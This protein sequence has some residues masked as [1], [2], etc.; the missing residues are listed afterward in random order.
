MGTT[1]QTLNK[2][3]EKATSFLPLDF[4]ESVIIFQVK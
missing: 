4:G 2:E 3:G 1:E